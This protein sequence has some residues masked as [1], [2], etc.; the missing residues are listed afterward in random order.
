MEAITLYVKRL[1]GETNVI[2]VSPH[3]TI[4]AGK[5]II[6]DKEN[7]SV[8]MQRWICHSRN[9][10]DTETFEKANIKDKD[11]IHLVMKSRGGFNFSSLEQKNNRNVEKVTADTPEYLVIKPGMNVRCVCDWDQCDTQKHGGNVYFAKGLGKHDLTTLNVRC[12]E[13][14]QPVKMVTPCFYACSYRVDGILEEDDKKVYI[15]GTATANNYVEYDENKTAEW[16][17]LII[18]CFAPAI[19]HVNL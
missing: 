18:R 9:L 13:C 17:S 7:I 5:Q 12:P 11:V 8:E 2:C 16:K 15:E 10:Q 6:R 1:T 19:P 4:L 14:T 3:T